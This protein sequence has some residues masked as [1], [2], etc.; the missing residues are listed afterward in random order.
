[1]ITSFK[2][3]LYEN[4]ELKEKLVFLE[5]EIEIVIKKILSCLKK[6]IKF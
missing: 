4:I 6:K 1:M 2:K 5:N 3:S